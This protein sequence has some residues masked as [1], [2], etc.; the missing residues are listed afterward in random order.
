MARPT[1]PTA[2][3]ARKRAQFAIE[4]FLIVGFI[5]LLTSA[6]LSGTLGILEQNDRLR[7]AVFARGVTDGVSDAIT[8]VSWEGDSA[9][10]ANEY[11]LPTNGCLIINATDFTVECDVGL[12]R[13]VKSHSYQANQSALITTTGCSTNGWKKV[14]VT[15][16]NGVPSITCTALA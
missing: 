12:D 15:N 5:L 2:N 1:N 7:D 4:F 8:F 6:L 16:A 10:V 11:Y 14:T 13:R 3:G 9:S